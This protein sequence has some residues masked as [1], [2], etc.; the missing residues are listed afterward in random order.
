MQALPFI[1]P[2]IAVTDRHWTLQQESWLYHSWRSQSQHTRRDDPPTTHHGH[3]G[4][5][6]EGMG[7]G[8]LTLVLA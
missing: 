3:S 2:G 6:P 8:G 1:G 7:L 4:T 5:D